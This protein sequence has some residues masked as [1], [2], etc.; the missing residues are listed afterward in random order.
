MAQFYTNFDEYPV[1]DITTSGQTDWVPRITNGSADYRIIDGGDA[2]GKFL[3]VQAISTNGSR[4]V[5]FAPLDGVQD[6]I[7]TLVKFWIFKSGSDG[8]TGRYGAAY[9]RYG[10]NTEAS[11]IGYAVGFIPYRS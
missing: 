9:T 8:S 5:G 11:T 6:N 1:G 4:V 10:G 7:E 3:R 2:D